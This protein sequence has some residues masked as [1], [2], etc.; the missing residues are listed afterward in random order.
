MVA[1]RYRQVV[2]SGSIRA[3]TGK[4]PIEWTS[5][6][7][8]GS[9]RLE[10]S[11]PSLHQPKSPF[12]KAERP[13]FDATSTRHRRRPLS[14]SQAAADRSQN[15]RRHDAPGGEILHRPEGPTG[16]DP[17]GTAPADMLQRHQF[18]EF[19]LVDVDRAGRTPS[20]GAGDRRRACAGGGCGS[21][22]TRSPTARLWHLRTALFFPDLAWLLDFAHFG[23]AV[24][25]CAKSSFLPF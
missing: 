1:V 25:K 12:R 7:F 2:A 8:R 22:T 3:L 4:R 14:H 18:V 10:P 6:R 9:L 5:I 15:I 24:P 21:P 19:G 20:L 17:L 23:T 11:R 16:H 13:Q